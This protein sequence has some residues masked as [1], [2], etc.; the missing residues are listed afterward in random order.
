MVGGSANVL[1][2][3]LWTNTRK[4]LKYFD[5][6]TN[7]WI[8][9]SHNHLLVQLFSHALVASEAGH[10]AALEKIREDIASLKRKAGLEQ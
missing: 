6:L 8:T 9:Y 3:G 4:G 2:Q 5:S 10:A 1:P 7:G